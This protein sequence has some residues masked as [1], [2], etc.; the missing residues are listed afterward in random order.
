MKGKLKYLFL[1][2]SL[3]GIGIGYFLSHAYD[4]KICGASLACASLMDKGDALFYSMQGLAVVFAALIFVP[5]ALNSWKKF[6]IWYLPIM[7]IYFAFYKNEGFFSI[8]E[9]DV[10]IF[11]SVLY[12]FISLILISIVAVRKSR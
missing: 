6:A 12:V 4:L 2:G 5:R 8:P 9:R 10:Y 1:S 7:F 3:I 11:F